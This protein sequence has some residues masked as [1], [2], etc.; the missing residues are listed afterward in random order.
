MV[1]DAMSTE[2]VSVRPE[3]PVL[4]AVERLLGVGRTC[5]P[6]V[7]D[8]GRLVGIL[9]EADL[10][11]LALPRYA[12]FLEDAAF[13]PPTPE[14]L[15]LARSGRLTQVAVSAIMHGGPLYTVEE[16]TPLVEAALL[17][18]RHGIRCLPVLRAGKLV[19]MLDRQDLVR[20]LVRPALQE[21]LS[22]P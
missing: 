16:D 11:R 18:L 3:E 7:D 21:P 10:L 4:T 9:S 20:A 13:L 5:L 15:D 17:M 19:G 1:R 14:L 8:E 22:E 12:D 2:V 6:V